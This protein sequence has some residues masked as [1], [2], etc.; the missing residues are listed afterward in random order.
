MR[1]EIGFLGLIMISNVI[2]I[3]ETNDLLNFLSKTLNR[4]Q[5]LFLPQNTHQLVKLILSKALIDNAK[6]LNN[7][8]SIH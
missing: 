3:K 8:M 7:K 6:F 1:I 4:V 5:Y 2:G